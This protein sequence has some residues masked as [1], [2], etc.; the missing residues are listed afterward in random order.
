M[1]NPV[2]RIPEKAAV[3]EKDPIN[4]RNSANY[5]TILYAKMNSNWCGVLET[6][7]SLPYL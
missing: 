2:A 3:Q 7:L 1:T 4:F 5:F 6:V